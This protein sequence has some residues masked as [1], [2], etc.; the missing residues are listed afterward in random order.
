MEKGKEAPKRKARYASTDCCDYEGDSLQILCDVAN[1]QP[2]RNI[3]ATD[4]RIKRSTSL[5][6]YKPRIDSIHE[7]PTVQNNI[8]EFITEKIMK[9]KNQVISETNEPRDCIDNMKAWELDLRIQMADKQ[10]KYNKIN[11]K[12]L[13]I[14]KLKLQSKRARRQRLK[15]EKSHLVKQKL[16]EKVQTEG[17]PSNAETCNNLKKDYLE[18]DKVQGVYPKCGQS[19]EIP[20]TSSGEVLPKESTNI[21][22]K[23]TNVLF[24]DP[25]II[26][27][28]KD[29]KNVKEED[30]CPLRKHKVDKFIIYEKYDKSVVEEN[31]DIDFSQYKHKKIRRISKDS[32]QNCIMKKSYDAIAQDKDINKKDTQQNK[33]MELIQKKQKN[34]KDKNKKKR[35]DKKKKK[36]K[37]IKKRNMMIRTVNTITKL[38]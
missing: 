31:N 12:L 6:T 28:N 2:K 38:S 10:R 21:N 30:K 22:N 32:E 16:H 27:D 36:K 20:R 5:D 1:L 14:Q 11:K 34:K 25:F 19:Q 13:K 23:N 37:D 15:M 9:H 7:S 8:K 18:S 24:I 4:L 3:K 35:K 29:K 33:E 26:N 17:L